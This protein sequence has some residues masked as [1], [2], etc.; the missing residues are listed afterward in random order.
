DALFHLLPI[1]SNEISRDDGQQVCRQSTAACGDVDAIVGEQD[2]DTLVHQF[3]NPGPIAEVARAAVNLVD[4][5]TRSL[6]ALEGGEHWREIPR[7][8]HCGSGG[9]FEPGTDG[10]TG[11]HRESSNS[12]PLLVEGCALTLYRSL[13]ADVDVISLAH[14]SLGYPPILGRPSVLRE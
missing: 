2:F 13:G 14:T 8:G 12:V 6:P 7:S 11:V 3:A 4:D 9:L 1:V 10:E 5:D